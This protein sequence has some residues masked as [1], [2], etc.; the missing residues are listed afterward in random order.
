MCWFFCMI[1]AYRLDYKKYSPKV[2]ESILCLDAWRSALISKATSVRRRNGPASRSR[3]V[4][5]VIWAVERDSEGAFPVRGSD[6]GGIC[7]N[8]DEDE[9]ERGKLEREVVRDIML[10]A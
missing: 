3:D 9:D 2:Q 1:R 6:A 7:S 8:I 10:W 5:I 4:V